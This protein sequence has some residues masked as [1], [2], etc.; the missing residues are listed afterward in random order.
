MERR[1]STKVDDYILTFKENIKA[2]IVE[3]KSG[4]NHE[5]FKDILKFVY[6]Y[7]KLNLTKD[8][9]GMLRCLL[10]IEQHY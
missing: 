4:D 2:F 9:F 10:K 1:I 8:D 7:E 6:D 5:H 3:N